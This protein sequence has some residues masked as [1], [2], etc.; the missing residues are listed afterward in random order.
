MEGIEENMFILT[1][2]AHSICNGLSMNSKFV[3]SQDHFHT[4]ISLD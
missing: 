4:E 1:V 2:Q 3:S